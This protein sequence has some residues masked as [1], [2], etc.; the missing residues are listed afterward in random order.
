MGCLMMEGH[1]ELLFITHKLAKAPPACRAVAH[2]PALRGGGGC[3]HAC[4]ATGPEQQ[5]CLHSL[6]T[7]RDRSME[8]GCHEGGALKHREYVA[9]AKYQGQGHEDR[10]WQDL[11]NR[12]WG[13]SMLTAGLVVWMMR[14]LKLTRIMQTPQLCKASCCTKNSLA[15]TGKG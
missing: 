11:S 12:R 6:S 9:G 3:S 8:I 2:C 14:L 7:S 1:P 15:G 4:C 13:G 5:P 10:Q